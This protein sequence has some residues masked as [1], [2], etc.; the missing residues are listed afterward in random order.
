MAAYQITDNLCQVAHSDHAEDLQYIIT[1]FTRNLNNYP[2]ILNVL[3]GEKKAPLHCAAESGNVFG[4]ALLLK[5]GADP[6]C[7]TGD[8]DKQQAIH[9]ATRIDHITVCEALITHEAHLNASERGGRSPITSVD[10]HTNQPI[11]IAAYRGYHEMV[12]YL[13]QNSAS[14]Q[15]KGEFVRSALH[16][17]VMIRGNNYLAVVTVLLE[18]K[19][20]VDL[21]NTLGRTPFHCATYKDTANDKSNFKVAEIL[22]RNGASMNLQDKLGNTAL[23]Y[24]AA[25]S[26]DSRLG[27]LLLNKGAPTSIRNNESCS[28]W[29]LLRDRGRPFP[30]MV[31][32]KC[33]PKVGE[34]RNKEISG[35]PTE[36]RM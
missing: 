5:Y 6:Y 30:D 18:N 2:H 7:I 32:L 1:H 22:L 8:A 15:A 35:S 9:L 20:E 26:Y 31:L 23:H 4:V 19:A 16:R 11:H 12:L 14:V 3:R 28:A 10:S 27:K 29:E 34:N 13:L 24:W 17:V 25:R 21:Q 33:K 36:D